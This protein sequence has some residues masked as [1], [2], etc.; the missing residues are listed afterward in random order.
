MTV[1]LLQTEVL[2]I[3]EN[4][5]DIKSNCRYIGSSQGCSIDSTFF[6]DRDLLIRISK[7]TNLDHACPSLAHILPYE[8]QHIHV[9]W[10]EM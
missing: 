5:A 10:G 6:C 2:T 3:S 9:V 8:R 1:A 7:L 4:N